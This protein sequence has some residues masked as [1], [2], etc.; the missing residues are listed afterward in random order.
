VQS[1]GKFTIF[2]RVSVGQSVKS[3]YPVIRFLQ[4]SS[5]DILYYPVPAGF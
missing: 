4:D 5:Y 3:D 2:V 1:A